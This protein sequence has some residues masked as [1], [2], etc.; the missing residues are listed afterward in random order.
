VTTPDGRNLTARTQMTDPR[1]PHP[2]IQAQFTHQLEMVRPSRRH[3]PVPPSP[4]GY[5]VRPFRDGDEAAYADLFQLAWPDRGT[6]THTRAHALPG[7]FLVLEHDATALL[8]AS[9]VA[10]APESPAHPADGSLGWLV[11]DPAHGARGLGTILAATTTNTLVDQSYALPWLGT[12]DNRL[13]AIRIYLSLG[14]QPN[15]YADGMLERWKAIFARLGR[16]LVPEDC[17]TP[18]RR[19]G[20][21]PNP[22]AYDR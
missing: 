1:T 2:Y 11:V 17:I 3:A 20:A 10:F 8:V 9:C 4:L 19:E 21:H 14:W 13:V 7:G 16:R 22:T 18:P 5:T 12:E 15:L 6:L